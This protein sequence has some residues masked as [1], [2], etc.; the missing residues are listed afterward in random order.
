MLGYA[1]KEPTGDTISQLGGS[2]TWLENEP[3]SASLARCK[4]C[5][6]MMVLLLQLNGD[7]PEYFPGHERRIHV[8]ACRN[9]PCRRKPGTIR[10]IRGTRITRSALKPS[11]QNDQI[12]QEVGL[13]KPSKQHPNLGDSIFTSSPSQ[14]NQSCGNKNPFSTSTQKTLNANPF[15]STQA[16]NPVP[17]G[18]QKRH[19]ITS[20]PEKPQP[21][22]DP[23]AVLPQTFAQKIAI[24]S[25]SSNLSLPAEP[26]PPVPSL[27]QP[28]PSY[29][30]DADYETLETPSPTNSQHPNPSASYSKEDSAAALPNEDDDP[31]SWLTGPSRADPTFLRFAARLAQNPEQVL[32][33]EFRGFPL[34]YSKNDDVGRTF[35]SSTSGASPAI[36]KITTASTLTN[37]IPSCQNCGS[38]RVFE[39]QLT[40]HAISELEAEDE[41]LE[42]MEWGT[43]VVGVCEKDCVPTGIAE[44]QKVGWMEEWV[45]VSWEENVGRE[46]G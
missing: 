40:P 7:L 33:Y 19:R 18:H 15:S 34:L 22:P 10:A 12:H 13:G 5:N 31:T 16:E 9:K 20:L 21:S 6:S 25:P 24:S 38:R 32:R 23:D 3:P 11:V 4:T 17:Y 27:P 44:Q 14:P 2:P 1:S 41:G 42:G 26:W 28:Y 30:L 35:P 39:F 46:K 29:Y 8:F 36:T 37:R 45:G 43:V